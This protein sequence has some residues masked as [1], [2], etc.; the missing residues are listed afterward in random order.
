[1]ATG[2]LLASTSWRQG[3]RKFRRKQ[4]G[5]KKETEYEGERGER[6][7]VWGG[8]KATRGWTRGEAARGKERKEREHMRETDRGGEEEG[9]VLQ[10][11]AAAD[12]CS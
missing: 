5:R 9:G 3:G 4:E 1:M 12:L 10:I 7:C 6:V 2:S 8:E 11:E